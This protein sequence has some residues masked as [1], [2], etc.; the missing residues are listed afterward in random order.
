MRHT[1]RLGFTGARRGLVAT[2]IVAA[3]S[4]GSVAAIEVKG[5]AAANT[6][7]PGDTKTS[8]GARDIAPGVALR[9]AGGP[10][11][12]P[13][14]QPTREQQAAAG[15]PG[16]RLGGARLE[17]SAA[18][19]QRHVVLVEDQHT[20]DATIAALG[21]T[22]S[23]MWNTALFGFV[24]HL[25]PAQVAQLRAMPA[26]TTVEPDGLV[27]AFADQANPPWGLDRIDQRTRP[28][29][30]KFTYTA[31]GAGVNAYVIDTGLWMTHTEFTGRTAPGTSF[32]NDTWGVWDCYGHGTH[33]AGTIGGTTYGVAKQ[34]TVVPVRVLD[35]DGLGSVS[36]VL[37]GI[38]WV[39]DDHAD[40]APAVANLS[41]GMFADPSSTM[42]DL[43]VEALIND[44]VTVVVAAG[45]DA[46]ETCTFSPARVPG[47]ITVAASDKDDDDAGFSNYGVCNDL[48]APG[49]DVLSAYPSATDTDVAYASGTSMAAP[50]VA[51]AAALI[52]QGS[53]SASPAEV[54]ATLDAASTKGVLTECCDDPDKLLY[55]GPPANQPPATTTTTTPPTTTTTTMQPPTTAQPPP[56][57]PPIPD[58]VTVQP[59]R[60]FDS[61]SAGG[62]RPAGSVTQVQVTGRAGVPVGATAAALNVTAVEASV[63][64]FMTVFPCGA[65]VPEASNL[66][67]RAGQTIPNAAFVKLDASGRVCVFTSASSSLLVD[68]NGYAMPTDLTVLD[69]FRLYDSRSGAG[70]RPSGS[71]TE[72][73]VA[74]AGGVPAGAAAALLNVTAVD[75]QGDGFMTVF[76]C[77][78]AVPLASNLNYRLGQTIANSVLARIG[79]GGK[80]CVYTSARAHVL[81]DVNA[82]LPATP[83]I[84]AVD[85]YR[86]YDTRTGHGPAGAGTTT[87]VQVA[88]VGGV[89]AGAVTAVLNVTAL[90]AGDA[91]YVTVFPCGTGVP[92]ASNL[93]YV[94]GDTIP[95][96]VIAKLSSTGA[97]CLYTSASA[98]LIVDVNGYAT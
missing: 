37:A 63:A 22:P 11:A 19:G 26:V 40:G 29:D 21:I 20:L 1:S 44:G 75:A 65:S 24:A 17:A 9:T 48:F 74:L 8:A 54:W 35:C 62:P 47:A 82:A 6:V 88:G 94:G 95:N 92:V 60:L 81:V 76:P 50:H 55:V 38:N 91:G 7:E 64:G 30:T 45:N 5:P 97:V 83:A 67:Y 28:L 41:L 27:Q 98:G 73:Q 53:P 69:P 56:P 87:A 23:D 57:V 71:V 52:L 33:V 25:S 36:T 46:T 58:L 51:G 85:P 78:T 10:A 70:T 93:N 3:V 96:A 13:P 12:D 84:A 2:L 42:V 61:R 15:E 18:S 16:V 72:V 79:A 39:A 59:T 66:N 90:D 80:V 89:P 77:G 49:V 68:V 4:T 34:V 14:P 31:T 32:V 43:A 86:L